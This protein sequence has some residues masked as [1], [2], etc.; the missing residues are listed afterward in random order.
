MARDQEVG[1][2]TPGLVHFPLEPVASCQLA[3]GAAL[4][5]SSLAY[6]KDVAADLYNFQNHFPDP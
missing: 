3:L 2:W 1:L 4:L 5:P 6:L